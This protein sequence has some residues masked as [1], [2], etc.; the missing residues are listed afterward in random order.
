MLLNSTWHSQWLGYYEIFFWIVLFIIEKF[1]VSCQVVKKLYH[2][3]T[4]VICFINIVFNIRKFLFSPIFSSM[5]ICL[6]ILSKM[7]CCQNT[8]WGFTM[9]FASNNFFNLTKT[10]VFIPVF[11]LVVS[12][13]IILFDFRKWKSTKSQRI[14][15]VLVR[16][17]P[18]LRDKIP[19]LISF[20]SFLSNST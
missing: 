6:N 13:I 1:V 8:N 14:A 7:W 3:Q 2:L 9:L 5:I 4:I 20:S 11:T 15:F 10:S 16:D 19:C 17:L 12:D 18:S